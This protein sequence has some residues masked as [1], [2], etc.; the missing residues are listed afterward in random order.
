MNKFFAGTRNLILSRQ[1]S[2]AS[3][4]LIV[5][6]MIVLSRLFGFLRI[7]ILA[8]YFPKETL[9]IFFAAFRIPDLVFEI[10][11]TGA[12]A[13]TFIPIF[14]K[15]QKNKQ[16]L[17]ENMSSIINMM[18]LAMLVF[19]LVLTA[20]SP[21]IIPLIIPGFTG[22]KLQ[23]T[24]ACSQLLL[25]GQLPFLILSNILTSIGQANKTFI[26]SSIAPVVYNLAIIAGTI[27]FAPSLYLLGPI[28]GVIIGSILMFL[29]QLPLLRSSNF[30]Y[31]P[32]LKITRAIHE[33]VRTM[34]PRVTTV[35]AAQIDATI[36]L[37]LATFMGAGSYSVFYFAQ[38]LQLL[39]VSIIGIA[40]GQASLPYLS[41]LYRDK[42]HKELNH[43]VTETL[44]TI[45]MVTI[46][47]ASF[48]IFAR[49]PLVRFFFGGEQ[50]DWEGTVLTAQTLTYF[51]FA[52]PAHSVYYFV[53][54][55]YFAF[56]D[57]KTPFYISLFSIAINVTLSLVMVFVLHQPVWSLGLA[58]SIAMISN[59]LILLLMLHRKKTVKIEYKLFVVQTLKIVI[60]T[61]ISSFFVY[62]LMKILDGLVID[63]TRTI[64]VFVLLC[65][66][67]TTYFVLYAF[68][69]WILEI[70]TLNEIKLLSSKVNHYRQRIVEIYNDIE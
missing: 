63:T 59:V 48:F 3:S 47:V 4:T 24:I 27:M 43:V 61:L 35:L 68:S 65:I 50:F 13:S 49:T 55:C 34:I 10:L 37:T 69:A 56:F 40:L 31:V 2:L 25:L 58:F 14:V 30:H 17:S 42:K 28:V 15:Y 33:F 62:C 12:L 1:H 66:G 22:E 70:Q 36:D 38:H 52:I 29:V 8:H 67:A 64:N 7:R 21:L 16:E 39:P 51:A 5:A 18:T 19:I 60:A 32:I 57:T 11:I 20:A 41:E 9:D 53:T 23:L 46:P 26:L 54:R 45:L 6:G 44:V